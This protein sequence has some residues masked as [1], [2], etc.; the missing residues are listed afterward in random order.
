MATLRE[1]I[2]S[3]IKVSQDTVDALTAQL[4]NKNADIQSLLLQD[5]ATLQAFYALF[6]SKFEPAP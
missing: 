6:K 2:Q 4:N 5:M 1:T 3:Q